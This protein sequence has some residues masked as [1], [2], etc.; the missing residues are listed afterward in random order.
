MQSE[1]ADISAGSAADARP[2]NMKKA[3]FLNAGRLVKPDADLGYAPG[4]WITIE[5][6]CDWA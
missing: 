4:R 2:K 3:A 6:P 5:A 1:L